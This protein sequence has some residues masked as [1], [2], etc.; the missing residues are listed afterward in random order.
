M[1]DF[2]ISEF[3]ESSRCFRKLAMEELPKY[4]PE[5]YRI[6]FHNAHLLVELRF[7]YFS[8]EHFH[9]IATVNFPGILQKNSH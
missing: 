6:P 2:F 9:Q 4:S 7:L 8:R 1:V 3:P 5:P